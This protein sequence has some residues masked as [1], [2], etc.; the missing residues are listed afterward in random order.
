[1]YCLYCNT[2]CE[3]AVLGVH[4]FNGIAVSGIL[5]I[6]ISITGFFPN[7]IMVVYVCNV[8]TEATTCKH[9]FA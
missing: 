2:H 1:M 3:S 4:M 8:S 9:C 6:S 7:H 5:S